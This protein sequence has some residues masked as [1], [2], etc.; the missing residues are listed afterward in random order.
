[1]GRA[2]ATLAVTLLGRTRKDRVAAAHKEDSLPSRNIS[3][4]AAISLR[5]AVIGL[6]LLSALYLALL[7]WADA[8]NPSY[9]GVSRL[10]PWFPAAMAMAWASW[11]L[12]Y[13]RWRWLL[14]RAG[15]SVALV[16]GLPAYIA[17]FAFTATPGKVGELLR[18]RYFAWQ[19]VPAARVT[20]AFVF[21]RA[22]DLVSLLLLA[23]PVAAGWAGFG[24]V[25]G[26]VALVIG[27]I[28]VLAWR[29][30]LLSAVV[31]ALR[32]SGLQRSARA[33]R[34]LRD[35]LYGCR[36]WL[37]PTDLLLS[38][39]LGLVAWTFIAATLGLMLLPLELQLPVLQGLAVYP[40]AMLAGAASM[41]PAGLG[42][43]EAV[44][45]ALLVSRGLPLAQALMLAVAIRLCT[46]WWSILCGF[47]CVIALERQ[48]A[49]RERGRS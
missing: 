19:G 20:A 11:G 8:Q 48:H 45:A 3:L 34:V 29:P 10:L 26:F 25:V 42:S 33:A 49:R 2:L 47:A 43:T 23:L 39:A 41:L 14:R 27:L 12:R 21:E 35:G 5:R 30:R 9:A 24:I 4:P 31:A 28:A 44:M 15:Y 17:G 36:I 7:L 32:R 13:L 1:M 22:I 37:R 6:A 38:L 40:L 16:A 18:I 46:M